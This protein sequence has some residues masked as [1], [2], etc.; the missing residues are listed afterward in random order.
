MPWRNVNVV[1]SRDAAAGAAASG[2]ALGVS[3]L[4]AGIF[5]VLPSLAEGMGNRVVDGVPAPVRDFAISVF[6]T[7][8]KAVLLTGIALVTLGLGALVGVAA[9]RRWWVAGVAFGGFAVLAAWAATGDP[10]VSATVAAV[11]AILA[12]VTGLTVL[13]WLYGRTASATTTEADPSR[14]A[15]MTGLG[16]V[17]GLAV[18]AMATGRVLLER[19]KRIFS[20][21]EDVVLPAAAEPLPEPGDG[22]ELQV[23]GITPLF[24]PNDDFYRIDTA[25][26]VPRVDIGDW[27]LEITGAVSRPYRLTYADILDM[28]MVERDVTLSCVSNRV[29]GGLVGNARWLG[30]PLVEILDR[31]GPLPDGEQVVA[32][33]VDGFTVGFPIAAAYDGR[34]ALLAVGING[35]P[36]PYEHGFPARL[37]VAGL[38]GYVSATKWL[39]TI[40]LTGCDAFDA[41]WIPRGWAKEGPVH[42]QSRID[43]PSHLSNIDAGPVVVAGVA[44]APSRGISGVEVRL[45]QD[46]DWVEAEMSVPLSD[47]AWVQWKADW[48]AAP[49]RHLLTVRATD[50]DGVVQDEMIR[51]PAPSGA[52]G[53][54]SIR[55][56][57]A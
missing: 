50:G 51:P 52:T 35:E 4:A 28:P 14:R 53:W 6:G 19:S 23:S 33:S 20:G 26:F 2:L 34:D 7:A 41:Y 55:V 37:V 27:S 22:A 39:Q 45:G 36:L 5:P 29:G 47:S 30:V 32:R 11:P 54:H 3:E 17:A 18:V 15:L 56:T 13:W 31:A 40:E 21:R 8:D 48:D 43:T 12:A 25:L 9:R 10:G 24:V 49:G 1:R 38:Y 57:V 42:T 46:S 44:W 16:A